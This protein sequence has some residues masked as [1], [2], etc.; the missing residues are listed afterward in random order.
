MSAAEAE[1]GTMP[2][3]FIDELRK[4]VRH[5]DV[6]LTALRIWILSGIV[7]I[8]SGMVAH[9]F[10]AGSKYSELRTTGSQNASDIDKLETTV[11]AIE[12]EQIARGN[13]AKQIDTLGVDIREIHKLLQEVRDD[14]IEMKTQ[15]KVAGK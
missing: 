5:V 15:Q 12:R 8:L 1:T 4:R 7:L 2:E 9:A 13:Q 6:K 10:Y 14:V 11:K 3:E